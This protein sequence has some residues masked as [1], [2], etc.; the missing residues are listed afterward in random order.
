MRRESHAV[1]LGAGMA[2]LTHAAALAPRFDRVSLV[3]RDRLEADPRGARARPGV[4]QGRQLHL[5]LPAGMRGLEVLLPGVTDAL[6]GLGAQTIGSPEWRVHLGGGRLRLEDPALRIVGA[7]RPLLEAGI[8]TRLLGLPGVDLLD[9]WTAVGPV[10]DHTGHRVTGVRLSPGGGDDRDRTLVADLVVDTTGRGS[11]AAR[12]LEGLGHAP[13]PVERMKVGVHYVTRSFRRDPAALD[14]CRQVLVAVPPDGRRGGVALAVE[15][16]RWQVTLVG[17]SGERPPSDLPGFTEYAGG[18]WAP[19]L[20]GVV[21]GSEPLDSGV[22]HA[23]PAYRR[24]RYDRLG[25]WPEGFVV[26]GDAVCSLNPV[27]AQGMTVATAEALLLGEVVDE[28]GPVG[29]GPR[30]LRRARPVLDTAWA[31]ATGTDLVHPEVEGA[32]P[33]SWRL[34]NRYLDR[35][36]TAAHRDP[37]IAAALMRVNGMVDRPT[38]LLRPRTA[39]RVLRGGAAATAPADATG[40]TTSNRPATGGAPRERS[41]HVDR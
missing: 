34:G 14:G 31:L 35:V 19:D 36:I 20:G 5:L 41:H 7:T 22:R 4:P 2:G 24:R 16:D 10:T 6:A 33:P 13:P 12:W 11:A 32:R 18:L 1:V 15:D 3:E 37:Q 21:T 9:G 38:A 30:L 8:R 23:F 26:S 25:D 28:H 40:T 17:L 39:C 29:A 27:L